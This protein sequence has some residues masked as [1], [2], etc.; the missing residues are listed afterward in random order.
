MFPKA[1]YNWCLF[2]ATGKASA[3]SKVRKWHLARINVDSS[4]RSKF[5]FQLDEIKETPENDKEITQNHLM[6]YQ[7]HNL[8]DNPDMIEW[9]K[10][11]ESEGNIK[12]SLVFGKLKN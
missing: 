5:K 12:H 8:S 2:R 10:L 11:D 3:L 4:S 6:S 7:E 1:K 9:N